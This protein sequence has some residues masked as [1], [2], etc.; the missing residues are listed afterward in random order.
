M[1]F[2]YVISDQE[3]RFCMDMSKGRYR[4]CKKGRLVSGSE[5]ENYINGYQGLLGELAAAK[6]LSIGLTAAC[7]SYVEWQ[8]Y[9]PIFPD[10]GCFEIKTIAHK[11]GHLRMGPGDKPWAIGILM[12]APGCRQAAKELLAGKMPGGIEVS[13]VGII[14]LKDAQ[15]VG[16]IN[17][18][19]G[20]YAVP[21]KHLIV[22]KEIRDFY[23]L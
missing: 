19:G 11:S 18:A 22:P 12:Y 16:S 13:V 8:V 7:L 17:P 20:G 21:Q 10:L 23:F 15:Q 4:E 2:S 14:K 9:N 6:I 5:T 1:S 3:H